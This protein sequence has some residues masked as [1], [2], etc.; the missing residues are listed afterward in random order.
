ME[1]KDKYV[2]PNGTTIREIQNK[3]F[4]RHLLLLRNQYQKEN[5]II[6]CKLKESIT[7]RNKD[8]RDIAMFLV[9]RLIR[10]QTIDKY[11]QQRK[12]Q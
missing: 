6:N 4:P 7:W 8:I 5:K 1:Y 11:I 3:R 2:I 9:G 12:L 10:K